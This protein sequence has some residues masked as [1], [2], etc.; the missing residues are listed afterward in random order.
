MTAFVDDGG[1]E[2]V[3]MYRQY[4]GMPTGHGKALKE[5]LSGMK[6]VNGL[7][8]DGRV[9]NG[10]P[11]LAAQVIGHFKFGQGDAYKGMPKKRRE[12]YTP[13]Y[14]PAGG[15]YLYPAGVRD[16]GEEYI[17]TLSIKGGDAM[18]DGGVLHLKVED[19]SQ[20]GLA[21][22]DGPIDDFDPQ[23]AAAESKAAT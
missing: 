1:T 14:L 17:Y 15:F 6:M 22:Y 5:F 16:C 12:K 4:D 21:L 2:I 10:M 13:K 3:V 19:A 18:N 9:A 23:E 11:C 8:G 20:K 7:G